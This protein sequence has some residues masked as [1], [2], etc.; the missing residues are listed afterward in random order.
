MFFIIEKEEE[1]TFDMYIYIL[2]DMYK[3]GNSKDCKSIK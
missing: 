2:F 3:S 1:T